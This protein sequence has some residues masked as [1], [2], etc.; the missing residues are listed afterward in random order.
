[1]ALRSRQL[2]SDSKR[3][4]KPRRVW[5]KVVPLVAALA[6]GGGIAA[7]AVFGKKDPAAEVREEKK[8]SEKRKEEKKKKKI[9]T[10]KQILKIR[11]KLKERGMLPEGKEVL[12]VT[13]SDL[14]RK[15]RDFAEE[16]G[17]DEIVDVLME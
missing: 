7:K 16:F 14:E 11:K 4:V 6:I 5:V 15:F 1:M 9:E 13:V 12:L 10:L 8:S 2:G 17:R 3:L